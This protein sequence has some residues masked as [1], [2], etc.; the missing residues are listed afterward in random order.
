MQQEPWMYIIVHAASKMLNIV[1]YL[2]S[3]PF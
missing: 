2:Y 1:F 3:K